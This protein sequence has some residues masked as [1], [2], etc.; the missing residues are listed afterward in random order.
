MDCIFCKIANKEIKSEIIF[1]DDEIMIFKDVNPVAPLHL[2]AIPKKH[3]ESILEID[4]LEDDLTVKILKAISDIAKEMNMD[5]E[6][7]RVVTN[8][9]E[10]AGQSVKHLHFHILGGRKFNWPPG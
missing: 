7:F 9:G 10:G 3:V 8:T 4:K 2:L 6:G 1:E 5:K